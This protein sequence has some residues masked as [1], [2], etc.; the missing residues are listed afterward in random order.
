MPRIFDKY[1]DRAKG[2]L[3]NN[4]TGSYT[5]PSPNL[6][7]HQWNWDSG[8]IAIGK[9]HY[10]TRAAI[11][12]LDSLF[13]GQ[14]ANGMLPQI[15]FNPEVL[16]HYFPEP[17]FWQADRSPHCPRDRITSGITMPPIHAVAVEHIYDHATQ[18]K[19][20][21]PFLRRIYP[22]LL[23]LHQYLYRERDPMD[24]GLVYIRHPWE[25]G[26][27]NSPAWDGSLKAIPV[28][29]HA[30]PS[31]SRR[32]LDHVSAEMRPS[33][34]DYDRYVYLV[35]LFRNRDY[36][37]TAIREESPFLIQDPLFNSILCRANR[38]LVRIA[39]IIGESA[40]LP[41]SWVERTAEAIR[42]KLWCPDSRMFYPLDLVTGT[43]IH[44]ETS[45]GF[46]PLFAGAATREQADI[47]YGRLNSVSFCS[48]HQG[49]CYTI[50]NYD[51]RKE[52]FDRTNYWR[53]PVWI[54]INWMLTHGLKR[55]GYTLK[56]DSLRRDLL[57]L[58]IRFGFREYFD[59]FSG[60]GYGSEDFSW[61]AALFIDLVEEFYREDRP[62]RRAKKIL[63]SL[64]TPGRTLNSGTE[65][66]SCPPGELAGELMK[67]IRSMR[68]SFYD[69]ERGLVDYEA[70]KGSDRFRD[71][72][73]L[74][75]GLRDFDPGNLRGHTDRLAFWVNLYNTLVVDAIVSTGVQRS[76]LTYP[77]FFHK[78]SY[79]IGGRNFSLD[80][81]EHGIL[82]GNRRGPF[83]PF[84]PFRPWD[85]R[86]K[87]MVEE[88]DPRVH[89]ALVCGSRSCAPIDYYDP[90][91][92]DLQM[93]EAARAFV[94]SSEVLV[95]PEEG[96]V[97]LSEIFR[98][99]AG[100]FGG[101]SGVIDFISRYLAEDETRDFLLHRGKHL[102]F[103]Y[104][105]YDWDLNRWGR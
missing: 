75:N 100:D 37:E 56:A 87:W 11:A 104:L 5:K 1:L 102:E 35:D 50:P 20:V 14:W 51:T 90:A 23:S 47:L 39:D 55:Y 72:R 17:D 68:D 42:T 54:N 76:V 40:D 26:V 60:R 74:T 10:D 18:R 81:V 86:K 9:S 57:Q 82:R 8:F 43:L 36:N 77:G 29:R 69:T 62:R 31:Y 71:Y 105:F 2:V 32:D 3:R 53:G 7:P 30:L 103:E 89:F 95:F 99:Y 93:D 65:E 34:D 6:Y 48:L 25:S 19:D 44:A 70:L 27:D 38:S 67:S 52:D 63:R 88:P 91:R 15:I 46:L 22:R 58:P 78:I 85:R 80:D 13:A 45:S 61:T 84:G 59:S 21:L 33:D 24:E 96:R 16:G 49:N 101:R 12:E 98:W 92:I 83:Y 79:A 4:W 73:V 94:N 41:R 28:D 64:M 66:P 97:L